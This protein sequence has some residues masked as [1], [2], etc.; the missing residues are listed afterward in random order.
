MKKVLI[1]LIKWYQRLPGNFHFACKY[2]PS[3]SN[4]MIEA[5]EEYGTFTGLWLGFKRLLRC[6]S[7]AK[8][9]YDPLK[10]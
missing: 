6:N 4:Y 10:K 1:K 5:L 9:G 8:G 2:Y 7:F 3:C